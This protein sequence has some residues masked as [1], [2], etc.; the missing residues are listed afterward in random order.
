[1]PRTAL[2]DALHLA[3]CAVHEVDYLLTWNFRHLDNAET[4]P[5]I[6]GVLAAHGYTAPEICTPQE[7]MGDI[8]DG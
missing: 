2:G 8:G 1:V 5:L 4:K 7:L 6:R 3:V